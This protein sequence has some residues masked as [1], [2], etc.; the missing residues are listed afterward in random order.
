MINQ[1][2]FTDKPYILYHGEATAILP[3]IPDKSMNCIITDP[4]YAGAKRDYGYWSESE[5]LSMMEI[6]FL[7]GRRVLTS[8]GSM[9][10]IVQPNMDKVGKMRLWVWEFLLWASKQWNLVQD[11]YWWNYCTL[12]SEMAMPK[13]GLMRGSLKYLLWFGNSNCYRNQENI[14]NIP[15]DRQIADSQNSKLTSTRR[16][17]PSGASKNYKKMSTAFQKRGGVTPSNVWPITNGN[18]TDSAGSNNHGAGTPYQ[19]CERLISYLCPDNG[20]VL[21]CFAG[22]GTIGQATIHQGKKYVGIEQYDDYIPIC[23][24]RLAQAYQDSLLPLFYQKERQ[25]IDY[26]VENKQDSLF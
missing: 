6:I 12:P 15:S 22:S 14:L 1:L 11:L 10:F 8:S 17:N 9:L 3:T 21:D 19:L 2:D 7:E 4:P 23:Q 25:I 16:G 13:H 18:S 26:R 20:I 5:W 24:K